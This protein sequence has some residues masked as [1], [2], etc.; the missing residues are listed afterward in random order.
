MKSMRVVHNVLGTP[1][2]LWTLREHNQGCIY[3]STFSMHGGT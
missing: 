3:G 1:P 2:I